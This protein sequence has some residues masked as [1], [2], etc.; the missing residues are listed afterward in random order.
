MDILL[1][2]AQIFSKNH[3]TT[4]TFKNL[5]LPQQ[6]IYEL[7]SEARG[8]TRLLGKRGEANKK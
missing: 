8:K 7:A 5:S 6:N 4:M 2:Q 1:R 3:R